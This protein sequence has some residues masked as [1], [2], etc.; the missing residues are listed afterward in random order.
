MS[1]RSL[2][3][4]RPQLRQLVLPFFT[5][6]S[7]DGPLRLSIDQPRH[8]EEHCEITRTSGDSA[9]PSASSSPAAPAARRV[10]ER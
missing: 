8:P 2:S 10:P 3:R 4:N 6:P 9:K 5:Q 7:V 1:T